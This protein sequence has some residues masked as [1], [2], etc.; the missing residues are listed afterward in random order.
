MRER[1][2]LDPQRHW[3][4][5]GENAQIKKGNVVRKEEKGGNKGVK[6]KKEERSWELAVCSKSL[7]GRTEERAM[8]RFMAACSGNK[9][10]DWTLFYRPLQS[11]VV[12]AATIRATSLLLY[13][14]Y[15]V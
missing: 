11:L 5:E 10:M 8:F 1:W 9:R 15:T 4:V 12:P 3:E 14:L 2:E 7:S 6:I 13:D